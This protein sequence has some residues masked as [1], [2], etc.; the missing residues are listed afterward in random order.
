MA[1]IGSPAVLMGNRNLELQ[2]PALLRH[3]YARTIEYTTQYWER[4]A[5]HCPSGLGQTPQ[6]DAFALAPYTTPEDRDIQTS[7]LQPQTP[8]TPGYPIL[9]NAAPKDFLATHHTLLITKGK[10]RR[11]NRHA[12]QVSAHVHTPPFSCRPPPSVTHQICSRVSTSFLKSGR[13]PVQE[14]KENSPLP[15]RLLL[16]Q[17]MAIKSLVR[18]VTLCAK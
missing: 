16:A 17:S 18:N 3:I 1:S 15:N 13:H 11:I 14:K 6:Q 4:S 2:S 5:Y 10:P 8:Q 9:Q 12:G 7:N